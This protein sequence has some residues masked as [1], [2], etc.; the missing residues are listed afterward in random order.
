MSDEKEQITSVMKNIVAYLVKQD[1]AP[2][3]AE[4]H[5]AKAIATL[6]QL[7]LYSPPDNECRKVIAEYIELWDMIRQ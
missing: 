5:M 2:A 1:D 6:N 3:S 4:L 7:C